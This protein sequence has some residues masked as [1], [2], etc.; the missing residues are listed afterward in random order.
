MQRSNLSVTD[1]A[2]CGR[3]V[4]LTI[5]WSAD[6]N[7]FQV[8]PKGTGVDAP[9][10]YFT[11][12]GE[13]ALR[14]ALCMVQGQKHGTPRDFT[15]TEGFEVESQAG[16]WFNHDTHAECVSG[17]RLYAIADN[18]YRVDPEH[19]YFFDLKEALDGSV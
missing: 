3:A 6:W 8:Y 17:N 9:S 1:I 18:V 19:V 13:D 4:G 16:R 11:G 7:E 15:M 14:T 10:A 2:A 5:R 12:D